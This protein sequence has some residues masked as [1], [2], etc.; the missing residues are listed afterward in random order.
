MMSH[1]PLRLGDSDSPLGPAPGPG[2]ARQ[3]L[4]SVERFDTRTAEIIYIYF[5]SPGW[6]G[7]HEVQLNG[8]KELP[9]VRS[10][11]SGQ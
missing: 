7:A 3:R 10:L 4:P 8:C 1:W 5:P 6:R 2:P 11:P 9:P